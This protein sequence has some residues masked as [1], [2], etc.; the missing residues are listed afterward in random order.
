MRNVGDEI[1][2][3]IL[4]P[5]NPGH[6]AEHDHRAASLALRIG[7]AR[8]VNAEEPPPFLREG[9]VAF[10]GLIAFQG[11]TNELLQSNVADDFLD[12]AALM[13]SGSMP[14]NCAAALFTLTMRPRQSTARTPSPRLERIAFTSFRCR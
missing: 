10:G 13:P 7:Q 14:S 12:V 5:V 11:L 6:I 2:T 9:H 3:Q 1:P 4:K 8:P